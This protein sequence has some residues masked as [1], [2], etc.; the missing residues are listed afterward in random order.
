M[1]VW[2][3]NTYAAGAACCQQ[4]PLMLV[5]RKSIATR[6]KDNPAHYTGPA[7][8]GPVMA[9]KKS[10]L[11]RAAPGHLSPG[12]IAWDVNALGSRL[13]ST[14]SAARAQH[15]RGYHR[16]SCYELGQGHPQG[17][18]TRQNPIGKRTVTLHATTMTK[19]LRTY[20]NRGDRATGDFRPV[21]HRP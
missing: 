21:A 4:L 10:I 19:A 7:S 12:I 5:G 17:G 13:V 6:P 14:G 15:A 18:E 9:F 20:Q 8:T 1:N 16:D 11:L 2:G 3:A